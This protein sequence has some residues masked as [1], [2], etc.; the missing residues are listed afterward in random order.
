M[1]NNRDFNVGEFVNFHPFLNGDAV[2]KGHRITNVSLQPNNFG[3]DVAWLSG[4]SGCISFRC[5]RPSEQRSVV[6]C[7][8]RSTVGNNLLFWQAGGGYTTSLSEAES[9]TVDEAIAQYN[10]RDT[11]IPVCLDTAY[12]FSKK[13]VDMQYLGRANSTITGDDVN[14]VLQVEKLYDGNDIAFVAIDGRSVTY[15]FEDALIAKSDSAINI[16]SNFSRSI[17]PW[18][19]D[20]L[21]PLARPACQVSIDALEILGG[22]INDA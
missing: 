15:N 11:D 1:N 20:A 21:A 4:K 6:L 10:C 7:D 5:L 13:R 3:D 22:V 12:K 17:K 8:T 2:S 18:P 9:F 19:H 14:I 16:I